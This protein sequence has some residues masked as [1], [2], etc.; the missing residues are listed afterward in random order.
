MMNK[1]IL[2]ALAAAQAA[3]V[4]AAT[5]DAESVSTIA[6]IVVYGSRLESEASDM[7]NAVKVYDA[8]A[9]RDSGARDVP[10]LLKKCANLQIRTL[11]ANPLQSQVAMRGFGEN[12]FGRVK[13]LVDGEEINS[14]DMESPN[15][16]RLPIGSIERIEVIHGASPILHGDGAT[17]GVINIITDTRDYTKKTTLVAKGGSY[18][19]LGL[20]ARTKGGFEE[21]GLLYSAFYD[22]SRS[23][24]Y[25][26]RSGFDMHT[27]GAT[28]RKIFENGSHIGLKANYY[29]A[30]YDM[31]GSLTYREWRRD[32]RH[33]NALNDWCRTWNYG[34][35]FDS[36]L[37]VG[38]DQWL[39]LD[40]AF[41]TKHRKANWAAYG[42][43]NE[44][45]LYGVQFA[46][47]YVNEKS[48]GDYDNQL[49]LGFDF[50][51]DRY[52][53]EDRSGFNNPKYH[54]DRARYGIFGR[55][56][57]F[58]T[59]ELSVVAG[60]RAEFIDNR[61]TNY[62]GLNETS[63]R[64][65]MGDYELALVYRPIDD[66][67]TFVKGTRFHRSA[68]CDELNYTEDG[69][70]LDPEQ[71]TSLDLGLE[72]VFAEEFRFDATGYWS[73]MEDEIFYNPYVKD[74]GW[75]YWGGYNCNS[76]GKTERL[77]FDL[78]ASW[79][80]DK[81]AE[82]SVRYSFVSARF[83]DDTYKGKTIPVVPES[84]VRAE[85]GVWIIDDLKA[86]LGYTFVSR[87]V[88]AG[89]FRNA[90]EKLDAYSLVDAGLYYTPTWAEG[91]RASIV[92]DN[93]L[94]EKYCDFAG[95][96]DYSGAYYYPA[97]GTTF[98]ITLSYEF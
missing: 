19:T 86:K 97:A 74:Y 69:R 45:D 77:G 11:N 10:E 83:A 78:G 25:R 95:W 87:Q 76:P 1:T 54:F 47:R 13:I 43:A 6:P 30:L 81:V 24:G 46:P 82:A 51:Y 56:E 18:G 98:M 88:L 89:D 90:H 2:A 38:E 80:R 61:W 55:E 75:G 17:A 85:V 91:W 92:L 26:Y 68:F 37:R 39:Y 64:D 96:S 73:V 49:T 94:N 58:L 28:L 4:C 41:S 3:C 8:A 12:S 66:L 70:F 57:F 22:Y 7:P 27:F 48:I 50:K 15:L 44:Y 21:E 14:V 59:D 52:N 79:S 72:Y 71:G 23:D 67:K 35:A 84:R 29:N 60:A 42:Y 33:A 93:L 31:P 34:F 32:P 20:A 5:N 40:A 36:K 53:V 9:I 16:T 63:S 62:R 65:W